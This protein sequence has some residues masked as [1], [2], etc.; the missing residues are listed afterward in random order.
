MTLAELLT[1]VSAADIRLEA[2]GDRLVFDA[3]HGALTPEL[4]AELVHQKP[5]LLAWLAPV[6]FVTL[7][8]GVTIP[9]PALRL[10]LDLEAR[11]IPLATDADHRFIVPQDE[12]LT[13]DDLVNMQRWRAHLGAIVDYRAPEA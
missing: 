9:V 6:E 3:P 11:G 10:A 8:G 12:R 13:A 7:K 5:A 1:V 2:R 4:R